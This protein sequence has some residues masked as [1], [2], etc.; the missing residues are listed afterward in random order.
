MPC[1]FYPLEPQLCSVAS[2][3]ADAPPQLLSPVFIPCQSQV[4]AISWSSLHFCL[5][6][7]LDQW[8]SVWL[9]IRATRRPVKIP[10]AFHNRSTAEASGGG[11]RKKERKASLC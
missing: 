5:S 4:S 11:G 10:F 2:L 8:L 1:A 9:L 6:C 7:H 3:L